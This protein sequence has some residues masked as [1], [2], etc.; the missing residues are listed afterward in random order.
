MEILVATQKSAHEL[1]ITEII[2]YA[3]YASVKSGSILISFK[4]ARR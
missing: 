1:F 4:I 2:K 3:K